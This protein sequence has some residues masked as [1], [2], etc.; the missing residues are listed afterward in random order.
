MKKKTL[1]TLLIMDSCLHTRYFFFCLTSAATI[2]NERWKQRS[3][4]KYDGH[5][6]AS[7]YF[8]LE[9]IV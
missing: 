7:K 3:R 1:S 4:R 5:E 8:A 9:I 6:Y 2:V